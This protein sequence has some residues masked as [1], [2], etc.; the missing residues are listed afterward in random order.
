MT[1]RV[2]VCGSSRGIGRAIAIELAKQGFSIVVHGRSLSEDLKQTLTEVSAYDATVRPLL[3][4]VTNREQTVSILN[5]ELQEA[6]AF[7]GIVLSAGL[8]KDMPFPGMDSASWDQV[9]NVDLNGFY[10]VIN[11]LVLPMIQLRVGGRIVVISSISGIIGNRG[12]VNYSAAKAGLIGASKALA[13]ELA[14][15]KISVN[16][17]APGAIET[18]MIDS[19][20]KE[21][22]LKMIPMQRLGKP[23]EVAAA[24]SYLFS[25]AA[26][27][28]TGQTLVLSGGL[29]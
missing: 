12:Q 17:V 10:N 23:E 28:M 8:T 22:M 2:F 5:D 11:P 25:P 9:I 20:L 4:D 18:E 16:C 15:R 7:Y 6:G 14:K 19:K 21:E 13:K 26:E 27:Y 3:F 1:K 29:G 24:V